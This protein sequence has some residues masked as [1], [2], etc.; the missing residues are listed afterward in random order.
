[1]QRFDRVATRLPRSTGPMPAESIT[2]ETLG[3][4]HCC[5]SRAAVAAAALRSP[6]SSA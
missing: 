2:V 6:V 3:A 5:V 1:V 4:L